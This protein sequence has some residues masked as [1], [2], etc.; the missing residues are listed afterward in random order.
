MITEKTEIEI[1]IARV[2][3]ASLFLANNTPLR[4][5]PLS[6]ILGEQ[7]DF[8]KWEEIIK[9][10]I[11]IPLEGVE[12]G[13]RLWYNYIQSQDIQD[14][15]TDWT[16]EEY[17]ES[18]KKMKE[19]KGSSPGIRFGHLKCIDP[20]SEAAEV[21]SKL[22]LLPLKTGYAPIQ[23]RKGINTMIPKKAHDLRHEKLRLILLMDARFNHN[24]KMIGRKMMEY[25]ED[26][27]LFA[28][29]QCGSRKANSAILHAINK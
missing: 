5:I 7:M 23:W 10:K 12:E 20:V 11:N 2:N 1:E 14:I 6:E 29:E 13:T 17:F 3:K 4:Q 27:N 22:A 19:E 25:R 24:N 9:G 15:D 8:E 28:E 21:I 26:N 16:T 18:W